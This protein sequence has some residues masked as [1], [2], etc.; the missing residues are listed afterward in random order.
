EAAAKCRQRNPER[1]AANPK[2]HSG[3]DKKHDDAEVGQLEGQPHV[4]PASEHLKPAAQPLREIQ[5]GRIDVKHPSVH[6]CVRESAHGGVA[7]RAKRRSRTWCITL[8][9]RTART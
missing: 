4:G 3:P 7:I 6:E 1:P 5:K 8:P 2:M 9:I